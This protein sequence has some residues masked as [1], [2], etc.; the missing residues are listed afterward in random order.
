MLPGSLSFR[1]SGARYVRNSVYAIWMSSNFEL[2][3]RSCGVD[4][5]C[6]R[7]L[8]YRAYGEPCSLPGVSRLSVNSTTRIRTGFLFGHIV[9]KD[10]FP[11]NKSGPAFDLLPD[12]VRNCGPARDLVAQQLEFT[13]FR[14]S[15]T[16]K[17]LFVCFLF[18]P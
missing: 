2:F 8:A 7:C 9:I 6:S 17:Y 3:D 12:T 18:P 16:L 4:R 11:P 10:R 1:R 13:H 15:L 5:N 14:N